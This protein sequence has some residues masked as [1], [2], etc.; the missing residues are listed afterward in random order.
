[1]VLNTALALQVVGRAVDGHDAVAMAG[2]AI[3]NGRATELL[4]ALSA[5]EAQRTAA[6]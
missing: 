6:P 1:V 2:A 3:D 5:L 4:Y